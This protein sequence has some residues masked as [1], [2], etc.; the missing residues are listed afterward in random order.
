MTAHASLGM[1]SLLALAATPAGAA[2]VINPVQA[3]IM[4]GLTVGI[5]AFVTIPPSFTNNPQTRIQY[6]VPSRDGSQR[7]F[8][9]DTRGRMYVTNQAG[10]APTLYLDV[11]AAGVGFVEPGPEGGLI[12]IAFHPNFNRDPARPG[13]ATFYTNYSASQASGVAN[14]LENENQSHENVVR[15]WTVADPNAAAPTILAS[16][17]IIRVGH[18]LP[19]HN[20]GTIAFNPTARVGDA[21]YGKLYIGYGDGGGAN[22]PRDNAQDLTNPLGK[23]LRIDPADPDGGGPLSYGIPSDN[24]F[25]G[26]AGAIGEVWA[27]G[28]RNPQQFSWDA[29]T[30]AMYISDIGQAQLEEVNLGA[31]GANYGWVLR[32]GT[33][34]KMPDKNDFN[35]YTLPVDDMGFV[36]PIAQ[37]DHDEGSAVGS[38]FV[39]RGSALPELQGL[40]LMSDIVNGRIFYFDPLGVQP[41]TPALLQELLLTLNGNA[42][43]F[44][45]SEGYSGRV[46]LR[47]GID[48]NQELYFLTKRD[49]DIFR[50]AAAAA[51]PEPAS[52]AMMIAG[53]GMVGEAMRR[54]R[55]TPADRPAPT[56]GAA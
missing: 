38:G 14:Y 46:D 21:D 37:Y 43:T 33:F 44:L 18:P 35:V 22:D 25:V 7:I 11:A 50:F 8:V 31:A 29:A 6:A 30:G 40:F 5:E 23:I 4:P 54:R 49:G 42:F 32:E 16:R 55:R 17:E 52:W 48:E 28:L 34:A 56:G 41:G 3:P 1:A 53:F 47:L 13:Y 12:G 9:N 24:P 36:Y 26:R 51:V 10:A 2:V 45:G 20:G 19:N 15:E 27:Y 39:Y